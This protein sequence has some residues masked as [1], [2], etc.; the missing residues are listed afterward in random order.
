M[1]IPDSPGVA[2]QVV[3][4][5]DLA[6]WLVQCVQARSAG[7]YDAVGPVVPLDSW[8]EQSRAVGGHTGPVIRADPAWLLKQG[9]GEYMGEESLAMWVVEPGWEGFSAR[10]G[11]AARVAGLHHRARTQLLTDLLAWEREQGLARPRSAGLSAARERELLTALAH[12][13]A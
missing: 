7:T 11:K 10:S 12:T 3:D 1:L 2:T 9:V 4:V 5:R 13:T 8:I 6:A